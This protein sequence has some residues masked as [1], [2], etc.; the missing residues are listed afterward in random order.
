MG[1]QRRSSE[2]EA[3]IGAYAGGFSGGD[4]KFGR[5][6]GEQMLRTLPLPQARAQSGRNIKSVF[7][8]TRL[9]TGLATNVDVRF[10][11]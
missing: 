5:S 7:G 9:A 10:V 3:E 6:H 2:H 8:F 1:R 4:E 11:A